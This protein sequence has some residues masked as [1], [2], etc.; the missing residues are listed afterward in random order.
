MKVWTTLGQD[1]MTNFNITVKE[2][3]I[4]NITYFKILVIIFFPRF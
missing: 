3:F 2:P 1:G 4:N